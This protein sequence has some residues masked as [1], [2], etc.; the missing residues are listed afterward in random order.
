MGDGHRDRAYGYEAGYERVV[1]IQTQPEQR[2][3]VDSAGGRTQ[4]HRRKISERYRSRRFYRFSRLR[5]GFGG[6]AR[7]WK[8]RRRV[9]GKPVAPGARP[10]HLRNDRPP[11]RREIVAPESHR[12]RRRHTTVARY[13]RRRYLFGQSSSAPYQFHDLL[14]LHPSPP[15]PPP[16]SPPP[17]PI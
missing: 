4:R 13:H 3:R 15:P 2:A 1:S 6:Q 12:Q 14:P 17:I 9:G 16:L 5:R 8:C 10:L 11:E 7:W